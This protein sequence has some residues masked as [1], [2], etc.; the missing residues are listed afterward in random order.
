MGK[1]GNG[2]S[3]EGTRRRRMVLQFSDTRDE[4]GLFRISYVPVEESEKLSSKDD[5]SRR[6]FRR[7]RSLRVVG[8]SSLKI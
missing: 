6:L 5:G 7:P 4:R 3:G 8:E 1:K 2:G